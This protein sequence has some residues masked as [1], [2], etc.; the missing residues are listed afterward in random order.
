MSQPDVD[1]VDL[2][3]WLLTV[4]ITAQQIPQQSNDTMP[5][6]L[7][8]RKRL[9]FSRAVSEAVESLVL[10]HDWLVGTIAGLGLGLHFVRL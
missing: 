7:G 10:S 5:S 4:A 6:P 2:A 9:N 1:I 3:S 8:P